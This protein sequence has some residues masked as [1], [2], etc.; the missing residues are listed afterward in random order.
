M[1]EAERD[2]LATEN[3]R[4]REALAALC[5]AVDNFRTAFEGT[6]WEEIVRFAASSDLNIGY[7][8][9]NQ[10]DLET[11]ANSIPDTIAARALLDLDNGD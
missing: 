1:L 8:L 4:L 11:L 2:A 7:V 3:A 5:A 9:F 6:D 10:T